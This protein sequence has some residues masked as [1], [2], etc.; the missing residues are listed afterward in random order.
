MRPQLLRKIRDLV[1]S[2]VVVV[3]AP[4]VRSP[5]LEDFPAADAE[6]KRL[7]EELWGDCNGRDSAERCFGQGRVFCGVGLS[8][9]FHR[10]GVTPDVEF[11]ASLGWTHRRSEEADIYFIQNPEDVPCTVELSFRVSGREPEIWYPDSGEISA[12]ALFAADGDRTRV[13]L[14]LDA[15][16]SVFVVFRRNA[17]GVSIADV[18]KDGAKLAP[19]KQVLPVQ[20]ERNGETF[21]ALVSESGNFAFTDTGGGK[22]HVAANL[23][24]PLL[25][26]NKWQLHF[27]NQPVRELAELKPWQDFEDESVK[28]FSGTATYRTTL[29][30][31]AQFLGAGCRLRLDLGCV[32]VLAEVSLNGEELGVLWKPPFAVDITGPAKPGSNTLVVKVTNNWNNRLVGDA[33]LPE[34][35]RTAF[36]TSPPKAPRTTLL[37]SGLSG[38]VRLLPAREYELTS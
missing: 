30:I 31:P 16:G 26:T 35:Q 9:V 38:P 18:K 14:S 36:I 37:P 19:A 34:H 20:V 7:A 27:P 3:G 15:V 29:D 13:T 23:P 22:W 12:T 2:G 1:A 10:L 4:P 25:V 6:V 8:E 11:S 28:Y 33:K 17:S 24:A 32:D 5:S 21:R